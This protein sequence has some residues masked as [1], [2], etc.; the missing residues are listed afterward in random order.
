MKL[1]RAA[2]LATLLL[3]TP[4]LAQQALPPDLDAR[5]QAALTQA[6]RSATSGAQAY[7]GLANPYIAEQG[8]RQARHRAEA[9][10][11]R[12]VLGAIAERPDLGPAIVDRAAALAPESAAAI[13][14]AAYSAYPGM[15]RTVAASPAPP[16]TQWYPPAGLSPRAQPAPA[17]AYTAAAAPAAPSV[18]MSWY[19]QPLL[20][21]YGASAPPTP[22]VAMAPSAPIQETPAAAEAGGVW[23]PLE[24]LNRVFH[25]FN[26][27]IDFILLRPVAWTY[28]HLPTEIKTVVRNALFNL[29]EPL[30]FANSILQGEVTYAG[31]ALGRFITN[32]TIGIAGLADV[33]DP[34]FGWAPSRADFGQTLYVWGLGAG[35]YIEA[36]LL[37]PTNARDLL[38]TAVEIGGDPFNYVLFDQTARYVRAGV[39]AVSAREEVLEP[40]DELKASSLDFYVALREA[41]QARRTVELHRGKAKMPVLEGKSAD[42]LFDEAQ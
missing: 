22:T 5:L 14:G 9:D 37:G 15:G 17:V 18:P 8:A 13:R 41:S 28:S 10:M 25:G 19:D 31:Q 23:D 1:A 2:G 39:S 4:A 32:S 12:A 20:R 30:N 24:G 7:G 34:V 33:A 27:G 40:L 38:G 16:P 3:V 11:A 26:Q 21:R 29:R 35:P 42:E 6:S 36:P